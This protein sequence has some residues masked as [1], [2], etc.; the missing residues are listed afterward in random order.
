MTGRS[1]C[2]IHWKS[3]VGIHQTIDL[4]SIQNLLE[5]DARFSARLLIPEEK[6][7]LKRIAA[8]FAHSGDSWYWGLGLILLYFLGPRSWRPQIILLL[9]GIFFT[10][11]SVLIMKFLIKRPRPEGSWGEIYRNSDPHSFP[12][13]HAARASMLTL[14]TFLSGLWWLGL[15]LLLWAILVDLSRICLGVH[16]LSDFLGGTL[17]GLIMGVVVFWV[18]SLI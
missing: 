1:T 2:H 9:A 8:F 4:M 17:F 10:A 18:Y 15:I 5:L 7:W 11:L 12:S 14:V 16:Y 13:G 3:L 6:K